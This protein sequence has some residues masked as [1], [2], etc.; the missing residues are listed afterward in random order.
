MKT[1]CPAS[2][3]E[4]RLVKSQ[5]EMLPGVQHRNMVS[6]STSKLEMQHRFYSNMDL[7]QPTT[8]V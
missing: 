8:E 5:E 1:S 2:R 4:T 3:Y 7:Y 6:T